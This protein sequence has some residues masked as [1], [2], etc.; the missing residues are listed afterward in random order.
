MPTFYSYRP[1]DVVHVLLATFLGNSRLT[2]LAELYKRANY[3]Q[4][5]GSPT[6]HPS[7]SLKNP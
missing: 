1:I 2:V 3:A 4:A 7:P 6:A 5:R